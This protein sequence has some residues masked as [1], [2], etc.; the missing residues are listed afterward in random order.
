[1]CDIMCPSYIL[2]QQCRN[3]CFDSSLFP[4]QKLEEEIQ[5]ELAGAQVQATNKQNSMKFSLKLVKMKSIF[6]R[7]WRSV[8]SK[9]NDIIEWKNRIFCGFL[10]MEKY[11]NNKNN[12]EMNPKKE[13]VVIGHWPITMKCFYRN[14]RPVALIWG[15]FCKMDLEQWS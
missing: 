4:E 8:C 9:S 11:Y 3:V 2:T 5:P 12:N 1:M 14:M 7:F 13:H 10:L 6:F 15:I